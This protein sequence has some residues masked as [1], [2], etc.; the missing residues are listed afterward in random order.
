MI[1]VEGP[2]GS[3]KTTLI[4]R[5]ASELAFPIMPRVV[6]KD[7]EAMVDL[8][9]WTEED[10]DKGFGERIYDR[11]RL[12]SEPIYGSVTRKEMQPGFDDIHWLS[13]QQSRL[14]SIR[15][16]V[17]WCLPPLE[18]VYKNQFYETDQPHF[19]KENYRTIYWLYF[20][21]AASWPTR[22]WVWDYTKPDYFDDLVIRVRS[23]FR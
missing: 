22:T 16:I 15:P 1:I 5:L 2:D 12:I 23:F 13:H 11:H 8:V 6:S 10:L 4:Q 9:K 20:N 14:R 19:V 21:Q 7:T 18:V 3:G 17:I